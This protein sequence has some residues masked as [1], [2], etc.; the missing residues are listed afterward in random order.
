MQCHIP[1]DPVLHILYSPIYTYMC[2][3]LETF[4]DV[5]VMSETFFFCHVRVYSML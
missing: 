4:V 1:S 5:R 3:F 2:A